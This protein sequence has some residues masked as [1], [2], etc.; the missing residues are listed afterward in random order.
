MNIKGWYVHTHIFAIVI[1]Q[2]GKNYA[3]KMIANDY[4]HEGKMYA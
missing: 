2:V 4:L 1:M 3:I